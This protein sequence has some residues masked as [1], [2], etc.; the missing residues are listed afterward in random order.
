[1]AAIRLSLIDDLV[2]TLKSTE[3]GNIVC[4]PDLAKQHGVDLHQVL[5]A[6][7]E[8][9]EQALDA[10][11]LWLLFG[12]HVTVRR[13][14]RYGQTMLDYEDTLPDDLTPPLLALDASARVRTVFECWQRDRGGIVNLPS[15]RKHYDRLHIHIWSGAAARALSAR[16]ANRWSKA[17]SQRS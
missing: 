7:A 17:S 1:V 12:K 5:Q 3:D 2:T 11:V 13:D 4:I 15:A 9:P 16:M 8:R 14:G 6:V 10:E